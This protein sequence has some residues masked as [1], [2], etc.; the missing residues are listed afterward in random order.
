MVT[1]AYRKGREAL[2]AAVNRIL[3]RA[4]VNLTPSVVVAL[5]DGGAVKAISEGYDVQRDCPYALG[6]CSRP[7]ALVL[8]PIVSKGKT[9]A[10]S[11]KEWASFLLLQSVT[12]VLQILC[13]CKR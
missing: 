5:V 10:L 12:D 3:V 7:V 8:S 1:E 4:G 2:D 9:P 11:N 6:D 13:D